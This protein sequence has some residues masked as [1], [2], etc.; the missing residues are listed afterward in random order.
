MYMVS[1]GELPWRETTLAG[2]LALGEDRQEVVVFLD[3]GDLDAL[4]HAALGGELRLPSLEIGNVDGVGLGDEAVDRGRG[5]EVLHRH[6]EAEILRRLVADRLD[7][8]IGHA[9]MAELDVLDL[10]RPDVG[11]PV[12]APEPA[13]APA[14]AA[15]PFSNCRREGRCPFAALLLPDLSVSLPISNSLQ[16]IRWRLRSSQLARTLTARGAGKK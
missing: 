6:R 11:K 10:L 12:I 14:T 3:L 2:E 16:K 13:A 4:D 7:H 5:V 15:A 9:D 8:R 1:Y